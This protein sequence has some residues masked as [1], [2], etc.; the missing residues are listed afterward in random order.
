[1]LTIKDIPCDAGGWADEV[2]HTYIDDLWFYSQELREYQRTL[3]TDVHSPVTTEYNMK[4]NFSKT[5]RDFFDATNLSYDSLIVTLNMLR[6][7]GNAIRD[8]SLPIV[9]A[10]ACAKDIYFYVQDGIVIGYHVGNYSRPIAEYYGGAQ[11]N[12]KEDPYASHLIKETRDCYNIGYPVNLHYIQYTKNGIFVDE[13]HTVWFHFIDLHLFGVMSNTRYLYNKSYLDQKFGWKVEETIPEIKFKG[14]NEIKFKGR[15]ALQITS[16]YNAYRHKSAYG[17]LYYKEILA[18]DCRPMPYHISFP[19]ACT[20]FDIF[21]KVFSNATPGGA[22]MEATNFIRSLHD[23]KP[24]M[25]I[26]E[27][28][29]MYESNNAIFTTLI[30]M[31]Y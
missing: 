13:I 8:K 26:Y 5:L 1:M 23:Y 16:A 9:A 20:K 19:T 28:R 3:H 10:M 27:D 14:R 15:N 30:R 25:P 21:N 17:W 4:R 11:Y 18:S 29:I 7:N 31:R 24:I 22:V 2:T 12:L 6:S